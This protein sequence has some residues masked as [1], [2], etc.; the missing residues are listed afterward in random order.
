MVA[1]S[2]DRND[3]GYDVVEVLSN[4]LT[5]LI[6]INN[7]QNRS[8]AQD[9]TM[10]TS[11]AKF[12]SSYAPT[13]SIH[14]YLQ[15]IQKY[16]NL[17][18]AVYTTTLIYIDRLIEATNLSLTHLNIHRLL[19]VAV[20][21]ATK[22]L[23][24]DYYKNCYYARLGGITTAELNSLEVAFL[25]LL[26]FNLYVSSSSYD[27]YT[28]EL[29]SFTVPNKSSA[30]PTYAPTYRPPSPTTVTSY[31]YY[32]CQ[33]PYPAPCQTPYQAPYQAPYQGPYPYY[34]PP[35]YYYYPVSTTTM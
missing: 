33:A 31:Y 32:P 22:F 26:S 2:N 19:L 11:L 1:F 25:S 24:D 34:Y 18:P 28:T 16:A 27:R 7:N 10:A 20:V 35:Y 23:Q 15:R 17:T 8:V 14:S 9:P 13:I 30:G 12:Q 21:V 29:K 4:V 6:E 3:A 5:Q